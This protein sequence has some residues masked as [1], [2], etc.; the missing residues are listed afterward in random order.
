MTFRRILAGIGSAFVLMTGTV[1]ASQAAETKGP[2]TDELG[3]VQV[4]RGRPILIGAY[5]VLSGPD[6]AVGIDH[7]RGIEIAIDDLK[8]KILEHPI[9][10]IAEDDQCNAEGGQVAATKLASNKQLVAVIGG[11]CSSSSTVGAP[12]LWK[13]GLASVAPSASAPALTDPNR[14]AGLSGFLRPVFN[15]LWQGAGDAKWAYEVQGHR[16]A[17]TIHDGSPYAQQLT[18]VFA[19]NFRKLGGKIT[20]SEAIAPTDTDMRPVLTRIASDKPNVIYF[21][22]YLAAAAH[23]ARQATVIPGLEKTMLVGNSLMAP[24]FLAVAGDAAVGFRFSNPDMTPEALGQGYAAFLDKYKKKYGEAPIQSWHHYAYDAAMIAFNAIMKTAKEDRGNLYI[25]R[26]TLRDALFATKDHD[27][28][29][30]RLTC[31]P[32]GDCGVSR[33]AIYQFTSKDPNTFG[34]GRNP[35]KIWP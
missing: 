33:P 35:V 8:G 27:G 4:T 30:G 28:L 11:S 19:Q 29:S 18:A 2:V 24:D 14:A 15:D 6:S 25:G 9:K 17:A 32:Y 10:L 3:V 23:I 16:T 22:V 1:V 5:L 12:I 26:K 7:R 31:N 34:V 13:A 21:P 20:S